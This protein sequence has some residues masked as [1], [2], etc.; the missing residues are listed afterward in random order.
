MFFRRFELLIWVQNA[1]LPELEE[2]HELRCCVPGRDI[3][4]HLQ[5]GRYAE[6]VEL[7]AR[8]SQC[9]IAV[10]SARSVAEY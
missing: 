10:L 6:S 5:E 4:S 2:L 9:V 8:Q 3:P 7:Y 1:L